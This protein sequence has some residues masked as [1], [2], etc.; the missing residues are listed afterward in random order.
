MMG[1]VHINK[2]ANNQAKKHINEHTSTQKHKQKHKQTHKETI[3]QVGKRTINI[4]LFKSGG[5]G[6]PKH[7]NNN[8]SSLREQYLPEASVRTQGGL[9]EKVWWGSD[10]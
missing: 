6:T 3:K 9:A 1:G 10:N 4:N 5:S 7:N 2:Q 8:K